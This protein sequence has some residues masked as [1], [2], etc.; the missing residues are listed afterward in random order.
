MR[1]RPARRVEGCASLIQALTSSFPAYDS[2]FSVT[3]VQTRLWDQLGRPVNHNPAILL[4]TQ[5][6]PP[7]Y[8]ENSCLYLFTRQTLELRRTRIGERPLMYEIPNDEAQDID[9]ELGFQVA[10]LLLSHRLKNSAV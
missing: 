8:A 10:D 2:L 9:D 3:R 5:D 7:I 6:L 1:G 4:R